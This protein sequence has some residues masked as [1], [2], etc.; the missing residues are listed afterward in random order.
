MIGTADND[1][2]SVFKHSMFWKLRSY[3]CDIKLEQRHAWCE[4]NVIYPMPVWKLG[5]DYHLRLYGCA[6]RCLLEWYNLEKEKRKRRNEKKE[7]FEYQKSF[8]SDGEKKEKDNCSSRTIWEGYNGHE[9]YKKDKTDMNYYYN[10]TD[11]EQIKLIT[12]FITDSS[13]DLND[14]L[15]CLE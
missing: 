6:S 12:L 7:F 2:F 10:W 11:N 14:M 4:S 5:R 1:S 9:H 15:T 8:F 3:M 13:I